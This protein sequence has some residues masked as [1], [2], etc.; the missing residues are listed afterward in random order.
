[1]KLRIFHKT[2]EDIKVILQPAILKVCIHLKVYNFDIKV[3]KIEFCRACK[4]RI[5]FSGKYMTPEMTHETLN[6]IFYVFS[7]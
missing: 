1:M 2:G 7:I 3:R 6:T 4:K 5:N